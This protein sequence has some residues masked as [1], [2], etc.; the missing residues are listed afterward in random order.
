MNGL[1]I[2]LRQLGK[3]PLATTL[4]LLSVAV[5]AALITSVTTV[6]VQMQEG[7]RQTS[8]GFDL[9]LAA[10]GSPLQSV[11][12]A[13][14]HLETST[15]IVPYALYEAAL[16]DPRVE[17]AFPL[18]VG[19][20]YRGSRIIGTSAS[21]LEMGEPMRG[22]RFQAAEG[23]FF[24]EAGE[25]VAGS[26]AAQRLGLAVGDTI[27]AAHGLIEPGDSADVREH[28]GNP[29]RVTGILAP[30]GTANDRVL[31]T[32]VVST[33]DMHR[34][35]RPEPHDHA[36]E[37]TELDAVMVKFKSPQM[38]LMVVST[39]NFKT[40]DHPLMRR[41]MERD[42]FFPFKDAVM[43]VIP[44]QQIANLMSI[45]GNGEKALVWIARLVAVVALI[46]VFLAVYTTMDGRRRDLA[47]FRALGVRRGTLFVLILGESMLVVLAGVVLGY[48]GGHTLLA[49][50]APFFLETAGLVIRPFHSSIDLGIQYGILFAGGLLAGVLPAW[51][52]YR[53]DA[54]HDLYR[55]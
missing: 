11:L 44:A 22:R 9:L 31:F 15:G 42:P 13:V 40:P 36:A 52:A 12:N 37:V 20:S 45:V 16:G 2:V 49:A 54:A 38:A 29:L 18:Y 14:Y 43:A 7:Y 41:Q 10:K 46:A 19:D 25:V 4:T 30:T 34:G 23:R 24:T 55:I 39:L 6:R 53:S 5:G 50:L 48:L 51:T 21:F 26:V 8:T 47:V 33:A 3:R 1:R 17:R 35:Y 28:D 32:D 27:I